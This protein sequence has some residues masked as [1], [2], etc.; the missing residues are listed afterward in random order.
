M[1]CPACFKDNGIGFA[2]SYLC[3]VHSMPFVEME[4]T[5]LFVAKYNRLVKNKSIT[6]ISQ[7]TLNDVYRLALQ[8]NRY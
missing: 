1:D 7:T 3:Y 6:P 8:E 2:F 5:F 4:K